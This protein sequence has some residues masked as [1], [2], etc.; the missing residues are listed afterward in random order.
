MT[1][2]SFPVGKDYEVN[3]EEW[4]NIK[5]EKKDFHQQLIEETNR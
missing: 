3:V 2:N 1:A 5:H 4:F